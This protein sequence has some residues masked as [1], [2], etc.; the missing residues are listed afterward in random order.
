MN[1][2]EYILR[3]R[4]LFDQL[5]QGGLEREPD[6]LPQYR[7][8]LQEGLAGARDWGR[9]A[10]QQSVVQQCMHCHMFGGEAGVYSLNSLTSSSQ[11][12][13]SLPIQG[14]AIPMGSGRVRPYPRGQREAR[15]KVT[16]EDYLRLVEYA[17]D[18]GP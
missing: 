2:H 16:Q 15:W 7:V 13:T 8:I 10:R 3:R 17:R 11:G 14:V 6:D 1:A 12:L 5:K 9:Y 4:L 18:P